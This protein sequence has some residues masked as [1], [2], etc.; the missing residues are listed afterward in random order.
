MY[1][2][3]FHLYRVEGAVIV[4]S[5]KAKKEYRG[6][7][8]KDKEEEAKLLLCNVNIKLVRLRYCFVQSVQSASF[9][10]TVSSCLFSSTPVLSSFL[11]FSL[12]SFGA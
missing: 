4:F 7:A 8:K 5:T 10:S 3:L 12:R 1:T 9:I 2:L 6:K 11:P